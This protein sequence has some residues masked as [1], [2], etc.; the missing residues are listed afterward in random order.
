LEL[1]RKQI[2]DL[3]KKSAEDLWLHELSLLKL[4]TVYL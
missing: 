4:W 3:E 1:L 2:I